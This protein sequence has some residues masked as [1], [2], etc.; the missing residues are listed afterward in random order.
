MLTHIVQSSDTSIFLIDEPDIYLHSD[1]QRQLLSL[2]QNL[3]PDILVATHSTEI[4]S[5]AEPNDIVLIDKNR[6][7][8]RRIKDPTQLNEVFA[9]LG[10]NLN[11]VLTQL[12]KTRRAIFVEGDDFQIFARFARKASHHDLANRA[13]FAVIPIG[14][15]ALNAFET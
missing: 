1:L 14:G 10:S 13:T 8:A 3:G 11:P 4:V 15:S 9:R 7:A 6:N 5:E 2:L 12:A